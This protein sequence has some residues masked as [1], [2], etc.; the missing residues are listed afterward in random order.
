M[1]CSLWSGSC[2]H[3][4]PRGD[5]VVECCGWRARLEDFNNISSRGD[6]GISM[7]SSVVF[8]VFVCSMFLAFLSLLLQWWWMLFSPLSKV[9]VGGTAE[10]KQRRSSLLS[11]LLLLSLSVLLLL[12]KLAE[13]AA[14][15]ELGE[16]EEE[17][18][19][20]GFGTVRMCWTKEE[21]S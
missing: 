17:E 4:W 8:S 2:V 14:G 7:C 11:L 15:E 5:C 1:S 9:G 6:R 21:G 12:L 10:G 19:R 18:E 16:E 20:L 3:W 13:G